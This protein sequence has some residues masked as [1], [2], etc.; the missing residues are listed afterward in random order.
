[1]SYP[2]REFSDQELAALVQMYLRGESTKY[3][4]K[5]LHFNKWTIARRL[6]AQMGVQLRHPK[7]PRSKWAEALLL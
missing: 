2:K 3:I 1:M 7:G 6:L 5:V 4:M